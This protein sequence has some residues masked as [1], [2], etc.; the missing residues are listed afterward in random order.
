MQGGVT[1]VTHLRGFF[2]SDAAREKWDSAAIPFPSQGATICKAYN[3]RRSPIEKLVFL[4]CSLCSSYRS[5]PRGL[6]THYRERSEYHYYPAL[7]A[8]GPILFLGFE[9]RDAEGAHVFFEHPDGR[10]TVV[11]VHNREMS[12]GL[13]RKV[14][15]DVNLPVAEYDELRK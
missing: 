4:W 15:N 10:T 5:I 2:I 12:K 6:A 13:L 9:E 11:S 14:L 8:H 3:F 7:L 1:A